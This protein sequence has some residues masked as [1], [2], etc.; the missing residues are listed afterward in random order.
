MDNEETGA[1][2][3]NS[4]SC[5]AGKPFCGM[6]PNTATTTTTMNVEEKSRAATTRRR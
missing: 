2:Y 1:S 3:R 5:V 4:S 6:I